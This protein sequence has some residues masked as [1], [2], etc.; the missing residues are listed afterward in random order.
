MKLYDT[1]RSH[2]CACQIINTPREISSSCGL[3][4][5]VQEKDAAHALELYDYYRP[6]TLIGIFACGSNGCTRYR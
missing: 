4:V 5:Q 2:G 1:F 6:E 3:S